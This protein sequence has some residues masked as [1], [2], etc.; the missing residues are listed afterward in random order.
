MFS[1]P[2]LQKFAYDL[3]MKLVINPKGLTLEEIGLEHKVKIDE[4]EEIGVIEQSKDGKWRLIKIGDS[5][6]QSR[7]LILPKGHA[8]L[9]FRQKLVELSKTSWQLFFVLNYYLVLAVIIAGV[10][11]VLIPT[12]VIVNLVGGKTLNS[13]LIAALVAMFAYVCT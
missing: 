8:E 9:N 6:Y 5:K 12:S 13:V 3:A 11:R 2:A 4:L 10:I 7:C 1:S